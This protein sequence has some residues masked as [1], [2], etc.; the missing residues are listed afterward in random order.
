MDELLQFAANE[1][2]SSLCI[3][4]PVITTSRHSAINLKIKYGTSRAKMGVLPLTSPH[5]QQLQHLLR[6]VRQKLG[7]GSNASDVSCHSVLYW[8]LQK[9]GGFFR[10]HSCLFSL[11]A[12]CQSAEQVGGW[13][14]GRCPS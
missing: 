7:L 10:I 13:S 14:T 9:S 8:L 11:L 5:T 4:A 12:G 3:C 6:S 2:R 1:T